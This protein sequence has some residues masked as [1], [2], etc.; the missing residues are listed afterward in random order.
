MIQSCEQLSKHWVP[1]KWHNCA[2]WTVTADPS[3]DT[4]T[5]TQLARQS[6][7]NEVARPE[8][9]STQKNWSKAASNRQQRSCKI[10][11][12]AKLKPRGEIR[13]S[14]RHH[15]LSRVQGQL[16][17]A[18]ES[19]QPGENRCGMR[20]R[21]ATSIGTHKQSECNGNS[22]SAESPRNCTEVKISSVAL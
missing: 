20:T 18:S 3:S 12:H 19:S 2:N 4:F 13:E 14:G 17:R 22:H 21:S 7:L 16:L 8:Q 5:L 6:V 1:E 10:W 11:K 15:H 9:H